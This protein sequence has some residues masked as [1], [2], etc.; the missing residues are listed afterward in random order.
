MISNLG[1][2]AVD[3]NGTS[4][5][6]GGLAA[7]N[8]GH[9][10]KNYSTGMVHGDDEI[11]GLLGNNLGYVTECYS[12]GLV[13]GDESVGGL[14][15]Y[16]GGSITT[17]HSTCT[18]IG[19]EDVGGLVSHNSG[20]IITSYSTGTVNGYEYVGGLVGDNSGSIT[21]SYS[22]CTVIG[23]EYVG[24]LLG[25]KYSGQIIRCFSTGLVTG[26]E[27]VGGL[28]GDNN[29][30]VTDSF[31]DMETSGQDTSSGGEG[32]TTAEMQIASTFLQAGWDFVGETENGTEDIW[33]ICEGTNYPRFVWQ[34]PVGDFV[35]PDG[36]TIDDFAFFLDHWRNDNCDLSNDYCQGTDLDQSG[37]V[38]ENDFDIFFEIWLAKESVNN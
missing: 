1:L 13:S 28:I 37:K 23:H 32:K 6:I 2:E 4:D 11:G 35:C 7:Y 24:G 33:S 38:D 20:G 36:I 14:V 18:V 27:D 9:I 30:D 5:D 17:S 10:T 19:H 12:A 8:E 15:G 3:V 31:W 34:V 16:N 21:T 22:T 29:A 26:E 25:R